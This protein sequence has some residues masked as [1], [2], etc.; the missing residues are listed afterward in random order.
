MN[1]MQQPMQN[2]KDSSY[3]TTSMNM[4]LALMAKA[5][6][7]NTISTNNN[8][9]RSLIPRNSQIAQPGMNTSQDIK[10]QMINDGVGNHVRHNAVQ[11]DGNEVGQNA[12]QNPGIQI[13]KN[14]NGL[15][16]VSKIANQY[17]NENVITTP[18]EGNGINDAHKETERVKVNC[19]SEDTLQQ[20]STSRTYSDNAP[21]YD[22]DRSAKLGDLKG[23]S[24]DT[25]GASNT[26]DPL[27]QKL[28]DENVLLEFQVLNYA[29]ENAHLKTTYKNLFDSIKVT[30]AQTNSIIDSLQKQL[31]DTIYENAELKA[32]LFDK[33]SKQKRITKGTRTNIMFA[34]QSILG[35]PSSSSY[36]PKLY[37]VTLFPKSLVLSKVDKTNALSKPVTLISA[38]TTRESKVVQTVNVISPRI[39]KTNPSKT[40]RVDNVVPNKPVKISVRIKPITVSQPNV[41]HKHQANF[42]S[43]GFSST[44]V[45]NTAKTRRPHPRSNYNTDRVPSKSKSGCLSNNVEKIKENHKNSQIP[46]IKSICHLNVITLRLPFEM[47]N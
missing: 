3:P 30:Q 42:D 43:N 7:V 40:S 37:Y 22:S 9:R 12:V 47:L 32:Q 19:T 23:K 16:F 27:S 36:K 29:K 24:S 26:L 39:F 17:G 25:Q 44:R 10:M 13:V 2:P 41:I 33:V 34:K 6:K 38:P 20:A 28:E 14:M 1:Y 5:F 45:N 11:N 18:A 35:K 8:Q 21:V 31:Y 4:A 46:R 15:S